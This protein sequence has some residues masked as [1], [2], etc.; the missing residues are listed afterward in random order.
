MKK[1]R[2]Y[3]IVIKV[4]LSNAIAYRA[5]TIARFCFYTLF[6]YVFMCLWRAI[7]QE[8]SV[9]GYGY[10]QIVWYLI[11]TEFVGYACATN[12][13]NDMNADVKSGAIAYQLGRPAH[14]VFYHLANSIGQ[15]LLNFVSF[16]VL[17]V[18]LGLAFVGPLPAFRHAALPPLALSLTLSILLN[19]FILMLIGLSA[20][21][22][23][24]NYALYLVYQ[25]LTFMLGM[26][27]P[28]EFL[29]SW[30]QP[31]AKNLPFS[32]VHWAPARILVN[33]SPEICMELI[34]RQAAWIAAAIALTLFCYR[35][36]VHRLELN[37][38]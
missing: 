4:S 31:V 3:A 28:V 6:V 32:Y 18:L 14:Y 25:K 37:G 20:F 10:A 36:C 2:K 22:M 11:M 30:L 27:L 7:Y 1:L 16:G 9:R 13:Y 33:Y 24:D 19:Y 12:V 29:P 34:P 23:E 8:G 17:A 21:V 15:V 5:A 26:F 35:L 38:G